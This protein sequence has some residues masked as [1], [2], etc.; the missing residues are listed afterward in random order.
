MIQR[1]TILSCL[2]L[3]FVFPLSSLATS[4][5]TTF[6]TVITGIDQV[7]K[8]LGNNKVFNAK[9]CPAH[10]NKITD[11]LFYLPADQMVPH[12]PAEI[13]ILKNNWNTIIQKVFLIRLN[14]HAKLQ[15]FDKAG[16]L[17]E[18]CLLKIREG[19]QYARFTSEYLV[20]WLV[21][22]KVITFED[23][24]I[25][26]GSFP[27]VLKDPSLDK[28]DLR[29]G[30]VLLIRG[31]SY[32]SAMIARIGDEEG[33]FSHL[34]IVGQDEKG[35]M[36]VVESLIQEGVVITPLETWRK[37]Q[38]ARVALYR[39]PDKDMAMKAA[40]LVY[41]WGQT[42]P[43]YDFAMDDSHYDKV[44]CSEVIR[45]A[46]DKASDGKLIVPKYRSHVSK[47]KNGPY[48][49]SLGVTQS[50]LFAP[51][52]IEVD[53]RFQY[54]AEGTFYPLLRQV[55][56]QDSIL[57]SMYEWMIKK[58]YTFYEPWWLSSE[59][60]LGKGLRYLGF[61]KDQM[62]TYMPLETI[63]TVLMFES[64]SDALEKNLNGKD[65]KFYDT[66]GYPPSFQDLMI[67][68][69]QKRKEDCLLY[70]S[71]KKSEFHSIFRG[72]GCM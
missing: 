60:T 6:A 43:E 33:N 13:A 41:D 30:D 19:L 18:E 69:E 38:D 24:P 14:L 23:A 25:L 62:P 66:R 46:F 8:D 32:V 15:D 31:K 58:D 7:L 26:A 49:R 16:T 52:D 53:P 27:F 65:K 20:E 48:P 50:T 11:W 2:V 5:K 61:L 72:K 36:Q 1:L 40:R 56:I 63:K 10:I 64:V 22:N 17:S 59:A 3:I 35:Q 39:L 37:S 57:Q 44:F 70:E 71:G 9:T 54:L 34:A 21:H 29:P 28:I 42:H 45:Y 47:F 12:D 55:R 51:Y 4:D 67:A 68:N